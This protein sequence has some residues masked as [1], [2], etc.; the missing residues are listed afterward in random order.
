MLLLFCL[1]QSPPKGTT[2]I[3]ERKTYTMEVTKTKTHT[4]YKAKDS[5]D[6]EEKT[7]PKTRTP[8]PQKT[9]P[10]KSTDDTED[11]S[12]SL[13][14]KESLFYSCHDFAWFKLQS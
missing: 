3:K 1:Y 6:K 9:T 8:A 12:Y 2:A 11:V 13:H 4:V 7:P 14:L 10:K 5:N